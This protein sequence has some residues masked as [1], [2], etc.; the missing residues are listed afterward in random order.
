M[1]PAAYISL[2]GH[3]ILAQGAPSLFIHLRGEYGGERY[4]KESDAGKD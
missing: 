4:G 1:V 3:D 2:K